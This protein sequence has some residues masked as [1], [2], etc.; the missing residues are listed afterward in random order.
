MYFV[1]RIRN[2]DCEYLTNENEANGT[3]PLTIFVRDD[4][5]FRI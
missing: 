3:I 4:L 5:G 1:T 2:T